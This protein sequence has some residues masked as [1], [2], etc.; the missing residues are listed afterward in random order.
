MAFSE[1]LGKYFDDRSDGK[2]LAIL[3]RMTSPI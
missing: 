2:T 3:S 1:V